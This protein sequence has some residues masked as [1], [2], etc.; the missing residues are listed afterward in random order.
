MIESI[1][2]DFRFS[3]SYSNTPINQERRRNEM[4][5]VVGEVLKRRQGGGV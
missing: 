5:V 1:Q 3:P 2:L 4:T